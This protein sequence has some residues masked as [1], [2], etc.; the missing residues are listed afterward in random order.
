MTGQTRQ[1][2]AKIYRDKNIGSVVELKDIT[3]PEKGIIGQ[4]FD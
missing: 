2:R 3:A 1:T 4:I